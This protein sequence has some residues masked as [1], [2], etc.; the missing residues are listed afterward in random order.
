V[1]SLLAG[2]IIAL[3]MWLSNA[4]RIQSE[5]VGSFA[6]YTEDLL[7]LLGLGLLLGLMLGLISW[8]LTTFVLTAWGWFVITRSWLAL[9]GQ[10]PWRLMPF[11]D[12]AYHRGVLRRTGATYQ[13]RHARLQEYLATQPG[14]GPPSADVEARTL[15]F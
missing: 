2:L 4:M 12:E 1:I 11:L 9:R 6:S 15:Q 13:F 8:P 10:L 14:D 5:H 7:T 3:S